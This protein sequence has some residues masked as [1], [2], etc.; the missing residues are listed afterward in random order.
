MW[1]GGLT[2]YEN[3]NLIFPPNPFGHVVF[4]SC[5]LLGAVLKMAPIGASSFLA[6]FLTWDQSDQYFPERNWGWVQKIWNKN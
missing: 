3:R 1:V 6:A 4:G 2:K 5:W